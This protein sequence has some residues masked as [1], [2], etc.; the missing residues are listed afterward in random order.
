[1]RS[2]RH[3]TFAQAI[4]SGK[5]CAE[6]YRKAKFKGKDASKRGF[7]IRNRPEVEARIA[8]IRAEAAAISLLTK[9]RALKLCA[10]LAEGMHGAEPPHRISA[11]EKVGKWSGWESGTKAEQAAATALGGVADMMS[12]IRTGNAD[13]VSRIRGGK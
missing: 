9:D 2:V 13:M 4:A 12:R 1:M 11:M 5:I 6:A 3:E 10:E 7:E 8:E